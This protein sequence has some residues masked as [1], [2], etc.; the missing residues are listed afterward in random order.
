MISATS[1]KSSP[2]TL[3]TILLG[4]LLLFATIAG[5]RSEQLCCQNGCGSA[6]PNN[7]ASSLA[8]DCLHPIPTGDQAITQ[9]QGEAAH[10]VF[11]EKCCADGGGDVDVVHDELF[12]LYGPATNA[13]AKLEHYDSFLAFRKAGGQ[14]AL[15][16]A[17]G[18]T[19][20]GTQFEKRD[21]DGCCNA[22]RTINTASRYCPRN[23]LGAA[24]SAGA[25]LCVA[26]CSYTYGQVRA[27]VFPCARAET[28]VETI[29]ALHAVV[30][31]TTLTINTASRYCPRNRLGAAIS[32][33]ALLC[34]A[35]CSYTYGQS[36]KVCV[37]GFL[38]KVGAVWV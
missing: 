16:G 3:V 29:V 1:T 32:A 37:S 22:C 23:R 25:L 9:C 28:D 10:F 4:C 26:A 24:I 15:S 36:S 33:G 11:A 2:S 12:S 34:V 31:E 17:N 20:N 13:S 38:F 18:T 6:D 5:V 8:F 19:V 14:L 30:A 7:V 27:I 21:F 35:A